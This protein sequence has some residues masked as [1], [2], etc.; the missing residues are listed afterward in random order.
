MRLVALADVFAPNL[1][2]AGEAYG[3][4]RRYADFREMLSAAEEA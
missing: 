4:E 3:V 2:T 1:E